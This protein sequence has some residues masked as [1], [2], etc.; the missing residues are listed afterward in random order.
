[1]FLLFAA[2]AALA[3][4]N[5]GSRNPQALVRSSGGVFFENDGRIMD[6]DGKS[7]PEILYHAAGGPV[8]AFFRRDGL[9]LVF[10]RPADG[11]QPAGDHRTH[12]CG[13]VLPTA[14]AELYRVDYDFIA[15]SPGLRILP[16]Q[17][18]AAMYRV[19]SGDGR[20]PRVIAAWNT[21]RYTD[22]YPGVDIIFR[23]A[24]GGLKYDV[25]IG[26][27]ADLSR[28]AFRVT[29]AGG[30]ELTEG[31]SLRIAS[32]LGT[33]E[34]HAPYAFQEEGGAGKS[35]EVQCAYRLEGDRIS[36]AV[37]SFDRRRVLV[38]DPLLEWATL[39]G[40]PFEDFGT[41]I[42]FD[43]RGNVIASGRTANASFPTTP[44]AIQTAFG[45]A[46]DAYIMKFSPNGALLWS[47]FLG[48]SN[49]DFGFRVATG[50][51]DAIAVTG[52][53][54]SADFPV[55]PGA[56]QP[57]KSDTG[58]V[59]LARL[60]AD[61][62]MVWCTFIGGSQ[63]DDANDVVFDQAQDLVVTGR[64]ESVDFPV[65]FGAYQFIKSGGV[66]AFVIKFRGD[67]TRAWGT[68]YGG[69]AEDWGHSVAISPANEILVSGHTTSGNF[70]TT[71]GAAQ[72]L[73]QGDRDGFLLKFTST[74]TR[75]YATIIGGTEW[76]DA[77]GVAVD[78]EGTMIA[79]GGSYSG[80]FPVTPGAFQ[81]AHQ[82]LDD[83]F[84]STYDPAGR[85]RWSTL[86]AGSA[87]ELAQDVGV[88]P[89]GN[90]IFSGMSNS[91]NLY[92]SPD[93]SQPAFG[94]GTSYDAFVVKLRKNG[95]LKWSTYCGGPGE[96]NTPGPY[97]LSAAA[98]DRNGQAAIT[99]WTA[100]GQFPVTPG[101]YQTVNAGGWDAFI[102]K[103]GCPL[104]PP[105]VI[106]AAG[107]TTFCDGDSVLLDAGPGYAAY[108]WSTGASTQTITVRASGDY[109]AWV[110][111]TNDCGGTTPTVTVTVHP[112]PRPSITASGPTTFCEGGSVV[113]DAGPGY[114]GYLWSDGSTTRTIVARAP[115]VFFV[116]V[117]S[118]GCFGRTEAV[119]VTVNPKPSPSITPMGSTIFCEGD[120]VLLDA[121]AGYQR[122]EWSTGEGT[123]TITVRQ[124][125]SYAVRVTNSFGC[126][127]LSAPVVVTVNP[128]PTAVITP[129]G[130]STFCEGDS[131]LLDAGAGFARYAWSTG[132]TA[133]VI[134][135]RAAGSYTVTVWNA[136]GCSATSAAQAVLVNPN[137][138]P[139]ITALGDT[140]FCAG[141]SV[142]LDAGAGYA[143]YGWSSGESTR[144]I[145][146]TASGVFTVTTA[147]ANGCS[148][149]SAP[150]SVRVH[151]LPTPAIT[152]GGPLTFCDGDSV[153]L[154]ALSG[155]TTYLWSTGAVGRS[156]VVRA[157]GD[158]TVTVTDSNGCQATAAAITVRVVPPPAV[159]VIAQNKD[160]LVSTPEFAYQWNFNGAPLPGE[161]SRTLLIPR[162]GEYT[163]TV[164]NANGCSSTSA[165]IT[166]RIAQTTVELPVIE[167]EPGTHVTIPLRISSSE[168]LLF[169]GAR[170]YD[171]VISFDKNLLMPLTSP[172]TWGLQGNDRT[173]TLHGTWTDT[174]GTLASFECL[175][176]LGP[177]VRTPLTIEFFDWTAGALRVTRVHG[178]FRLIICREGGD[179]LFDGSAVA[180]LAQNRPN[181]FN[182]G[183][184]IDYTLI[185]RGAASLT[186]VD[187]LGRIV[188]VLVDR[189]QE[190]GTYSV[191]FDAGALPSG[192]YHCV[193]RTPTGYHLRSMQI[194]R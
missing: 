41:G 64:T 44:G 136:F 95:S 180:G 20:T 114:A 43:S 26:P 162:S 190:P 59:F 116:D 12:S 68:F 104:T 124:G 78:G 36:Y 175:A 49:T 145:T 140:A 158:Y 149:T 7:C 132:D 102:V 33:I 101:A 193:L 92:M 109:S 105:P 129:T 133:R 22:V 118:N 1:M 161:R 174:L 123:R 164:T 146:V 120:S 52:Y 165:P 130:S 11:F 14:R 31:G 40:G 50:A 29:G 156:I 122:Y 142:Q 30:L 10:S 131:V 144:I 113:L 110:S 168:N 76:D 188:A 56:F 15:P 16:E 17:P 62:S 85:L 159:P 170:E 171:A 37:E 81:T 147:F 96:D 128:L 119:A 107:P 163:V 61:G 90:L 69:G 139:A 108:L 186:V 57:A 103:Y 134:L 27:G 160:T 99:G 72:P 154:S 117:D 25:R 126:D 127:S 191:A 6:T 28:L 143:T 32:P 138:R 8:H 167:A 194:L 75:V 21:L 70:P 137:P 35:G 94:G 80:D 53:T 9:S 47:T 115:G 151:Q 173:L 148:G 83:A 93:A 87:H 100:N 24:E 135:V 48:G 98:T 177:V 125:G 71:S 185:E 169:S 19:Y 182:A 121:G 89:S 157:S 18:A 55:T 189:E 77:Y 39:A 45:G 65:T 150:V 111:D 84:V 67:G 73:W 51:G 112:L 155:F 46:F 184:V 172:G 34:D 3:Q 179:R 4:G 153:V 82:A 2:C 166:V 13:A 5:S 178:E 106:A 63:F 79:V 42:A 88:Y 183:T 91:P 181:P 97:E 58:D 66:D 176:M 23:L 141:G 192:V 152:A 187:P 60:Q 86:F 54:Q 74:G 38:I